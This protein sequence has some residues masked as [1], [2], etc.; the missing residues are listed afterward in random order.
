MEMGIS[1]WLDNKERE[2]VDVSRITV[3]E[4]MLNEETPAQTVYFKE[5]RSCTILCV[6]D[7]PFATVERYG[8]W[9]YCRGRDQ[10]QGPHTTKPQWWLWTRDVELA[11]KTARA[12]IEKH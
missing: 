7:H 8:H 2:G 10:E 11:L 1:R 12:H 5:I 4:D 6:K 9:F 3:P